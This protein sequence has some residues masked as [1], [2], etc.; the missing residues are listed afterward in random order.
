M[1]VFLFSI[2]TEKWNTLTAVF[3]PTL[4]GIVQYTAQKS[5]GKWLP[6]SGSGVIVITYLIQYNCFATFMQQTSVINISK[7]LQ[8]PVFHSPMHPPGHH[9]KVHSHF[10]YNN[11]NTVHA[12]GVVY[13]QR[14]RKG[15]QW[16]VRVLRVWIFLLMSFLSTLDVCMYLPIRLLNF[17][18]YKM[19]G[20]LYFQQLQAKL[21][22]I[23]F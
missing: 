9:K 22:T 12:H 21:G 8:G 17:N 1:A 19:C 15:E 13:L 11:L 18:G 14:Y 16:L 20:A 10:V 3:S 4:P 6:V 7:L 2:I 5:V 23:S